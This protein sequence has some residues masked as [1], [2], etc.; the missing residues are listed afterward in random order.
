MI[1]VGTTAGIGSFIEQLLH[2]KGYTPN[3]GQREALLS[4]PRRW[5]KAI[6]EMVR[7]YDVDIDAVL[8]VQFDDVASDELIVL[9]DVPFVS[10]CEHHLMPFTGTASVAYL[11]GGNRVVGLSKLARL[12]EAHACRFQ[13]QERMTHDIATDLHTKLGARGAACIVT[14]QHTCMTCRGIRKHGAMV[15]SALLGLCRT[16]ASMRSEVLTLLR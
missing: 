6:V 11:P 8:G 15:T 13:V 5:Q 1:D 3:A 14:G 10:V 16:D 12:I 2:A 7:G 9:R 4:T